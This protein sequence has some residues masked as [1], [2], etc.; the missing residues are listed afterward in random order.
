MDRCKDVG[1]EFRSVVKCRTNAS[2]D[3]SERVA[4]FVVFNRT[5]AT[6]AAAILLRASLP[7]R[8]ISKEESKALHE[9]KKDRSRVI[10]KADKGNCLVVLDREEYDSKME[11]LLADRNTYELVSRSPFG[12]IERDLNATLLNLK[13]QQ[14]IDDYTYFK[15][16]STDG[17][18]PAIRGSIPFTP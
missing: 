11:S 7:N 5:S 15:L 10:M 9:L 12:R 4:I 6:S 1:E 13:R 17:I 16:R 18:P 3:R 8:N 2:H 14:K